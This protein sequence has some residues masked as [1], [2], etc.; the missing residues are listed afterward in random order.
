MHG[1]YAD[2]VICDASVVCRIS[3]G[4]SYAE[5]AALPC[6]AWTAY[7]ALFEKLGIESGKTILITGGSG[8][9]GGFA[10]QFAKYMRLN[11]ITTCSTSNVAYVK[12]LGADLVVDYTTEDIFEKALFFTRGDGVDYVLETVSATNGV[13]NAQLLKFSGAIANIVGTLQPEP[14]FFEKQLS[15]HH[16]FL[17]GHHRDV[18]TKAQL[19]KIGDTVMAMMAAKVIKIPQLELIRY[20]QI[21]DALE[22]LRKGHVRGKI[23]LSMVPR[24]EA[25]KGTPKPEQQ[26]MHPQPQQQQGQQPH[27]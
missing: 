22:L 6:A 23:V 21:P 27:H 25:K 20:E 11:V 12:E 4:V 14:F 24:V 1:S 8:G 15:S 19:K 16:V 2:Y 10:V 26:I 9:V 18:R 7:V 17:G 13:Q 5:A 3:P